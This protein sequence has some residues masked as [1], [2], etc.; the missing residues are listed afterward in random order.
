MTKH[1]GDE[2]A[3]VLLAM[4]MSVSPGNTPGRVGLD[5]AVWGGLQGEDQAREGKSEL[6]PW[7]QGRAPWGSASS[8]C[9]QLDLSPYPIWLHPYLKMRRTGCPSFI[10][11]S[12]TI[13]Q[14]PTACQQIQQIQ[15][16]P[17]QSS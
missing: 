1:M 15:L 17:S 16:L 13:Y 10:P 7:D 9:G 14:G 2:W 5:R 12:G 3:S 8:T 6:Q 4:E 11:H